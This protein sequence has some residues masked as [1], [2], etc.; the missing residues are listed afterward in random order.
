MLIWKHISLF[1]NGFW[2]N[3]LWNEEAQFKHLLK[4]LKYSSVTPSTV[5]IILFVPSA[6]TSI[7]IDFKRKS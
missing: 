7:Y 3:V 6:N 5:A 2:R 1:H 4:N